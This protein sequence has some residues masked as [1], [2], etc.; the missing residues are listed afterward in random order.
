LDSDYAL[1]EL[2]GHEVQEGDLLIAGLGDDN[3]LVGRACVAPK[4][5][6]PCLVK[7][8]CFRFRLDTNR[9]SPKFLAYQLSAG[10]ITDAQL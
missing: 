2:L 1:L 7:A 3:N 4:D 8:D 6:A 10:A 9:V 5:I